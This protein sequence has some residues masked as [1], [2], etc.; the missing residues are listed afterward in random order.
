M[1]RKLKKKE[2]LGRGPKK[3]VKGANMIEVNYM[4]A[5]KYHNIKYP[6]SYN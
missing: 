1:V 3:G 5:W 6:T 2:C 4:H